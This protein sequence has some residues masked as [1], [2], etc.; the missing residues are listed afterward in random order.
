MVFNNWVYI[1]ENC[2]KEDADTKPIECGEC[3]IPWPFKTN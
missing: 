2:G 3:G 1:C